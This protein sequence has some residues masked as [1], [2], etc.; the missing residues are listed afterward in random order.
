MSTDASTPP[1][2]TIWE[3]YGSG[4][5]AIGRAVAEQL[6]LPYHAQ[7]FSSEDIEAEDSSR[8]ADSE[9]EQVPS[10]MLLSQVLS[11]MGGAFGGSDGKDFLAV[12]ESEHELVAQNNA[13]VA[14]YAKEGGVIVGRNATVILADRPHTLHVLLTG[15]EES[16]AAYAAEVAGI[17]LE[18]ARRR[19]KRE[20]RVRT[21]M[22]SSLYGWD[23]REPRHYHLMLTTSR[24]SHE[25]A[26]GTIVHA[27]RAAANA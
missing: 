19:R 6:G 12:S 13:T 21:D 14:G 7:A 18:V 2:V 11:A 24:L 9:A 17:S 5:D 25:A 20:D 8:D 4:A 23:P 1:V 16:R 10:R 27:I 22:S 26:V 15:D 3:E